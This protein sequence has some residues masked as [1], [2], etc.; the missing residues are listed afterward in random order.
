M[1]TIAILLFDGVEELDAIGP[2]EVFGIAEQFFDDVCRV[3]TVAH[4]SDPVTCVN[5]LRLLPH[6]TFETAPT[7]DI[8]VVPGGDGSRDQQQN[9]TLLDWVSKTAAA[10][11]LTASVCTGLRIT[12]AAGPARGRRVTTHWT[13][14]EE[15]RN[16]GDAGDVRDDLRF[17][18]DGNYMSSSGVSAGIDMALWIVGSISTPDRAR[19]VHR[20]LQYEPAPPFQFDVA[21]AVA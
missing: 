17:I 8:L 15:I 1:K 3:Y 10:A 19:A 14:I 7:P 18:K 4:S 21:G 20:E 16:R 6:H 12:L 2:Y 11:E 5:G 13:A 9:R